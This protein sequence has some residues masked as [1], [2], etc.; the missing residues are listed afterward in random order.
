MPG[1]HL[2]VRINA[3]VEKVWDFL[4]DIRRAPE[5]VTVMEELLEVSDDPIRQGT[6]YRE[7]SRIGPGRSET[8]WTITR[9][10]PPSVQVH[11]CASP[12][13]RATLTMRVEPDGSA[14]RLEHMTEYEMFPGFRPLGWLI[15][16]LFARR[17][18]QQELAK[19]VQ[20]AK[21]M[22]ESEERPTV[23]NIQSEA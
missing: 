21:A 16:T 8:T 15:E 5:W 13:M 3:P 4:S 9:L 6:V 17:V 18:M 14:A 2:S 22:L 19:T 1:V 7:R 11:E 12:G 20:A 10:E 23:P